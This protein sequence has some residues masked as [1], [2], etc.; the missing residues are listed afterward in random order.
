MESLDGNW[1]EFLLGFFLGF[2][3]GFFVFVIAILTRASKKARLGIIFG[4]IV[5]SIVMINN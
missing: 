2:V 4:I 5:S 3:F 1:S